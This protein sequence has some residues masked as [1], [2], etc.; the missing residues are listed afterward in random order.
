MESL[1]E[2]WPTHLV[3]VPEAVRAALEAVGL[4]DGVP[5]NSRTDL[6]RGVFYDVDALALYPLLLERVRERQQVWWGQPALRDLR[7]DRGERVQ[8]R[9]VDEWLHAVW[10]SMALP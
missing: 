5:V 4:L 10:V 3:A 2:G 7:A 8:W 1:P 6:E 9:L